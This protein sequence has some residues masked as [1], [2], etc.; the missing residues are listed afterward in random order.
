MTFYYTCTIDEPDIVI[1]SFGVSWYSE[2]NLHR[3]D[4]PAIDSLY[5]KEWWIYGFRHREDGPASIHTDGTEEWYQYGF[6]HREAGPA[7]ICCN[8]VKLYYLC[9]VHYTYKDY[10]KLLKINIT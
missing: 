9:G 5:S 6:R 7:I 4:G 2:G 1:N 3:E 8:G 10:Y